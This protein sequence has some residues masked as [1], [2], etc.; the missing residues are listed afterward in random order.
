MA[1]KK[2]GGLSRTDLEQLEAQV[3]SEVEGSSPPAAAG[4]APAPMLDP[5]VRRAVARLVLEALAGLLAAGPI[6]K[7]ALVQVA[8]RIVTGLPAVLSAGAPTEGS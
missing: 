3:V 4:A 7:T 2:A 1:K 6:T 5:K 8:A